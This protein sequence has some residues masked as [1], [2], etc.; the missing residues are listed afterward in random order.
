MMGN[1]SEMMAFD[2]QWEEL[3]SATVGDS[4]RIRA[5]ESNRA[6]EIRVFC[7]GRRWPGVGEPDAS[8]TRRG[9][10]AGCVCRA[11]ADGRADG[12]LRVR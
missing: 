12:A 2:T 8:W 4:D 1:T 6:G 9:R 5:V 7:S 3:L 10:A 11:T